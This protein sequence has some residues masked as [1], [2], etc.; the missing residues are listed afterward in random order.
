MRWLVA[1][2]LTLRIKKATHSKYRRGYVDVLYAVVCLFSLVHH[3]HGVVACIG[4]T[5]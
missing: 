2:H 4:G 3:T 1:P 5:T